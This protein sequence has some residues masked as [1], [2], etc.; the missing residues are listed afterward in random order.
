[1]L[2]EEEEEK[3]GSAN[4][5]DFVDDDGKRWIAAGLVWG[6]N[7][8]RGGKDGRRPACFFFGLVDAG[9]TSTKYAS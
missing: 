8:W 3:D 1:M 4:D 7:G 9:S 2:Q 6:M 5:A